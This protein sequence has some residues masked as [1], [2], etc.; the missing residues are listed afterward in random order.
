MSRWSPSSSSLDQVSSSLSPHR[1][2][3]PSPSS[4]ASGLQAGCQRLLSLPCHMW[5]SLL[6]G[7]APHPAIPIPPAVVAHSRQDITHCGSAR[8][9]V[10]VHLRIGSTTMLQIPPGCLSLFHRLA[11]MPAPTWHL[12]LVFTSAKGS[13]E[14]VVEQPLDRRP[15]SARQKA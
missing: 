6:A 13:Q 4:S 3:A 11:S 8:R 9:F 1:H 5:S 10:I 14:S 12:R 7:R 15:P 2:V